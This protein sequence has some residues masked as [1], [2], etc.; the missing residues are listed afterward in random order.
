MQDRLALALGP[1]LSLGLGLSRGTARRLR[2]ARDVVAVALG[3]QHANL[4][5]N[6][7]CVLNDNDGRSSGIVNY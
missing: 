7:A 2:A 6:A 4:G 5:P 1:S 3:A